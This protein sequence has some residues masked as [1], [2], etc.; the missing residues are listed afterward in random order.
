MRTER[1]GYRT[2][3]VSGAALLTAAAAAAWLW[4]NAPDYAGLYV[5][6]AMLTAAPLLAPTKGDFAVLCLIIAAIFVPL[7]V[8][9]VFLGLFMFLPAAAVLLAA[10]GLVARRALVRL[11]ACVVACLLAA[12]ALAGFGLAIGHHF[13]GADPARPGVTRAY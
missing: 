12:A 7:A 6:V 10:A 1:L 9:G 13:S 11:A 8:A 2:R 3:L 4:L 5:I